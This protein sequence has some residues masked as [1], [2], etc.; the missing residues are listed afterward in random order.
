M[1]GL[2]NTGKKKLLMHEVTHF[3]IS[4]HKYYIV[5]SAVKR[6]GK[7]IGNFVSGFRV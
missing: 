5:C 4:Y 2:P 7:S 3:L 6:Q 1:Y